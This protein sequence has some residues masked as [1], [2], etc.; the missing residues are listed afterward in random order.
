MLPC[1]STEPVNTRRVL[2]QSPSRR[3]GR[4]REQPGK[5]I[6]GFHGRERKE[7]YVVKESQVK[8]ERECTA[9]STETFEKVAERRESGHCLEEEQGR[10]RAQDPQAR[11]ACWAPGRKSG[12]P[13]GLDG[14]AGKEREEV[15][16]GVGANSGLSEQREGRCSQCDE[17]PQGI[18]SQCDEKPQG[19]WGKKAI[20]AG[21]G[22]RQEWQG[23]GEDA[24]GASTQD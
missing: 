6:S 18:W 10:R 24:T 5:C 12:W 7:R 11:E 1:D 22:G 4:S 2:G 23:L 13:V 14:G 20:L 17:K 21:E 19:F 3:T 15:R 8:G 9:E 16:S